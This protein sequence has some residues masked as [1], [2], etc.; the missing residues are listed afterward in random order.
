[1]RPTTSASART[2]RHVG[3]AVRNHH[4]RVGW[5]HGGAH[6]VQAHLAVPAVPSAT[7]PGARTARGRAQ[8]QV[9]DGSG[10][11]DHGRRVPV[12]REPSH[13]RAQAV[14]RNTGVDLQLSGR[15]GQGP[16]RPGVHR[17][18][19]G[20]LVQVGVARRRGQ[21]RHVPVVASHVREPQAARHQAHP[22]AVRV[23]V[24]VSA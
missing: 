21:D 14:P 2:T 11:A 3:G 7:V 24:Q 8:G 12:R 5:L 17:V 1:V 15:A 20:R 22:G 9:V 10:T 4:G 23:P 13:A 16:R 18:A 6:L 19:R